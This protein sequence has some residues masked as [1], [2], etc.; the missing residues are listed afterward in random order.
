MSSDDAIDDAIDGIGEG[1][2]QS[3]P[4]SDHSSARSWVLAI[5]VGAL[6][7]LYQAVLGQ[8]INAGGAVAGALEAA[9]G[10][11]AGAG[12]SVGGVV[13]EAATVPFDVV[14]VL[15]ADAGPFAPLLVVGAWALA[16]AFV[17]FLAYV[18]WRVF[19]WI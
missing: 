9:G 5:L 17:G 3:F 18:V 2:G 8:F 10:A 1:S 15:A 12:G 7:G 6:F 4:W 14:A 11:V 16:A 13:L 19:T